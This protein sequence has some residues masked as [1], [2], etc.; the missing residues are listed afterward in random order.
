MNNEEVTTNVPMYADFA[1]WLKDYHTG[2]EKAISAKHLRAWGR[3]VEIRKIVNS[4]RNSG[5][6][7]CS[8]QNGYYYAANQRE[9]QH[10]INNLRSRAT[11]ITKAQE[12]LCKALDDGTLTT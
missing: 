5:V 4:L 11:E 7:I 3:G 2:A 8:D 9:L 10:T 1:C 6:P 12:G